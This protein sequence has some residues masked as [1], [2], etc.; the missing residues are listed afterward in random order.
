MYGRQ[1]AENQKGERNSN[2]NNSGVTS[3]SRPI[4]VVPSISRKDRANDSH[5]SDGRVVRIT[6]KI[7]EGVKEA[8][9]F[10]A[11]SVLVTRIPCFLLHSYSAFDHQSIKVLT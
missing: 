8:H 2:N 1:G 6:L 4:C 11:Q 5:D 7:E 3:S 9:L 10:N